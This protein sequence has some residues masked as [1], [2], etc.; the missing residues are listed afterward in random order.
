ALSAFGL[1]TVVL[2]ELHACLATLDLSFLDWTTDGESLR[3]KINTAVGAERMVP[4]LPVGWRRNSGRMVP[5]P[6]GTGDRLIGFTRAP[7]GDR[8]RIDPAA[9][10]V[11]ADVDGTVTATTPDGRSWPVRKLLEV[12]TSIIAADAFKIGLDGA[13][14]P[15]VTLDDL[16]VFR[17]TWRMP[18]GGL[19][20]PSKADRHRDYL[21]VRRWVA[22]NTLPDR[23]YVK[24]PQ[25][26]KPSLFDFTS[27][28]LVLSFANLVRRGRR[29]DPDAV[30]TLSEPLP[31]PGDSW[32]P[33]AD[34]QRYVSEL[35]LQISRKAT[36]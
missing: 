2:G 10:I 17:E 9:A 26:T 20:L 36:E 1:D 31:A 19:E 33:D 30:M 32:L 15:R 6:I 11:L 22:E 25:E 12:L 16:V 8:A 34:G 35:R 28:T 14:S 21:A 24:F 29:L 27:P 23:A 5:A 4:L 3:D 13:H 7:F 18:V